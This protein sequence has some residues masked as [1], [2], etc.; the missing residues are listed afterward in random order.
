MARP[1]LLT[2][3]DGMLTLGGDPILDGV[4]VKVN[5]G[6]RIALVGRNGSGKSTLMKIMA[7]VREMDRGAR[8]LRPR[9]QVEMLE[10]NPDFAGFSSLAEFALHD[11]PADQ[12][13]LVLRALEGLKIDGELA[14]GTA[15]GGERRRAALARLIASDA[16]LLLLDE[17]TN[18]LDVEAIVWLERYLSSS[19]KAM[20]IVSHDRRFLMNTTQSVIWVDRGVVRTS[21]KGF[22]HFE[23]WRDKIYEEEDVARHKL[24]R[25][26]KAEGRWAVEGISARRKRNM[27]RVR[28]LAELREEHSTARLRKGTAA[29]SLAD[30]QK[31]GN[32][33]V[34]AKGMCK[35]YGDV[36]IVRDFSIR[37][38]R[39]ERI[40]FVGP[41]GV[42]KTTLIKMLVGDIEP[43]DGHIKLGTNLEISVFDQTQAIL[44]PDATPWSTLTQDADLGMSGK[45]D[46]I[47]VQGTP[48]HVVGYLKDFLFDEAQARSPI[49]ALS[50]GERVRLTLARLFARESNLLVLDEPTNDLDIETL[51]L[52]QEVID[53]YSGTVLLV[54]H[55]RDFV[56]RIAE[57]TV[58]FEGNG[59]LSLHVGGYSSLPK[60]ASSDTVAKPTAK[61]A[62]PKV[63]QQAKNAQGLSF[64]QRHRLEKLPEEIDSVAAEI[65]KI[66]A[67]L[68][69]PG[70]FENEPDKCAKAT[71]ALVERQE[72]LD[73]LES[74]WLELEE[75]NEA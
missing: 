60:R 26:I 54:S 3:S 33:V 30:A 21:E 64:S 6:A 49:H 9:S 10:Q 35:T 23:E 62:R 46:Q 43:D 22:A 37:I 17:P 67:F 45:N 28:R 29:L 69:T 63:V 31:S 48:R 20:I 7:G 61:K 59:V 8:F 68:S 14:P 38:S 12:H 44:D 1:P 47:L 32:L 53:G 25:L 72:R 56:D 5:E 13:H 75:K 70:V 65:A 51:D 27:G 15:S 58:Y 36:P 73:G 52:L 40:G 41:N 19:S 50:G 16:D 57:R 55:D 18:H 11:K 2:I 4:D 34:D 66:E 42:G 71:K 24:K 74:E 39:G